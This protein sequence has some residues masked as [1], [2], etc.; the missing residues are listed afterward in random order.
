M[1]VF[2]G[3]GHLGANFVK[4]MLR[5]GMQVNVWNRTPNKAAELEQFGAKAFNSLIEA[6]KNVD[7]IHLTLSDD[8]AVDEV[9][10]EAQ[11]AGIPVQQI[12]RHCGCWNCIS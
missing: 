7:Q 8:A 10:K 1:I 6:V 3:M 11:S 5:K 12:C 9:L 4:A 2:L